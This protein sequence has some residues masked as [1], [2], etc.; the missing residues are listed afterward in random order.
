MEIG[1]EFCVKDYVIFV[2][3]IWIFGLYR[4]P[5]AVRRCLDFA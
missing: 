5:H 4:V 1:G 2:R 3:A